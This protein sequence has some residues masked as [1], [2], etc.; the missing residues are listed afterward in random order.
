M[1]FLD[2]VKFRWDSA[3]F[4]TSLMD[5]WR[6]RGCKTEKDFE[7][8]LYKFL[9]EHLDTIQITKQYARCRIRADLVV[10]D[11]V[12][13]ELKHNLNTTAKYQ[14]LTGQLIEYKE[15]KGQIVILLTGEVDPNLRKQ[16]KG[17][18]ESEEFDDDWDEG[19]VTVV[20]K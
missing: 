20:E 7:N 13:V 12:I 9:H 17:F 11:D 5:K 10:G 3:G 19:T 4:V 1:G 6:P 16:L 8:S 14:R 15:W 18:I 2:G